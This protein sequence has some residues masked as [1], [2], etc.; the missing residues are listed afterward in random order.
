M[1]LQHPACTPTPTVHTQ[2]AHPACTP[3]MHTQHA[4]PACTPL[5]GL[6]APL[7]EF[8]AVAGTS[9]RSQLT[10]IH[11]SRHAHILQ[12]TMHTH[13]YT[14]VCTH[15]PRSPDANRAGGGSALGYLMKKAN[16]GRASAPVHCGFYLKDLDLL[17]ELQWLPE[18]R[19]ACSCAPSIPPYYLHTLASLHAL[20]A[21]M[22]LHRCTPLRVHLHGPV[23]PSAWPCGSICMALYVHLHGPVCPSAWPC[24]SICMALWVHLHG[25]AGPSAWP[26]MSICMALWVHLHGPVCPS[27]WPCISICMALYIHLHGPVGPSAWPCMSICMALYVHLHGPVCPS[28]WPYMSICMALYVHLHTP[29][30]LHASAFLH[31][32]ACPPEKGAGQHL[33]NTLSGTWLLG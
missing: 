26:C 19:C 33:A 4:H 30:P 14:L 5:G 3:S 31:P 22:H 15:I 18:V 10:C 13:T 29:A 16:K 7:K 32:P 20:F 12:R 8:R 1:Q 24:M 28:A 6:T 27:A 25:P 2:R 21:C 17:A 23:C 9:T 11:T